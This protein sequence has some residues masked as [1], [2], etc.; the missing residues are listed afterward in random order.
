MMAAHIDKI[1]RGAKP[2]DMPIEQIS[3]YEFAINLRVARDE[4]ELPLLAARRR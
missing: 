4:I 2:A 3:K 1:L